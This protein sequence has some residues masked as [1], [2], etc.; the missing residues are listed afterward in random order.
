M[1]SID[2]ITPKLGGGISINSL[3]LP[4]VQYISTSFPCFV[5]ISVVEESLVPIYF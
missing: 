3:T 5:I 1:L 2:N 4:Q